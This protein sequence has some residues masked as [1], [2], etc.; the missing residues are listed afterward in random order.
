MPLD[1]PEADLRLCIRLLRSNKC[2][3]S[4]C[5]CLSYERKYDKS[6][7]DTDM[8]ISC[9][10][11]TCCCSRATPSFRYIASLVHSRRLHAGRLSNQRVMSSERMLMQHMTGNT[12][13]LEADTTRYEIFPGNRESDSKIACRLHARLSGGGHCGYSSGVHYG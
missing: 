4:I 9:R 11:W 5:P 13:L 1:A 6:L 2:I 3:H 12:E 10:W 8:S 7:R